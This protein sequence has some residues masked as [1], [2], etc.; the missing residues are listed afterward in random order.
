MTKPVSEM[1]MECRK[2]GL[3]FQEQDGKTTP[4]PGERCCPNCNSLET[5]VTETNSA[6]PS[7]P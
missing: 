6:A 1:I 3:I 2:C 4:V 5:Y 7:P